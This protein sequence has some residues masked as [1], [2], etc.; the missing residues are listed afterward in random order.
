MKW[1]TVYREKVKI[2]FLNHKKSKNRLTRNYFFVGTAI[3]ILINILIFVIGGSNW[4]SFVSP[5][6]YLSTVADPERIVRSFL[7]VFSHAS[8][9]WLI[10]SILCLLV[11]GF[12]LER[13]V[14]SVRFV[15]LV[16]AIAFFS[17][18]AVTANF[19][20]AEWSGFSVA[21]FGLFGYIAA[22][23]MFSTWRDRQKQDN[24]TINIIFDVTAGLIIGGIIIVSFFGGEYIHNIGHYSALSAGAVFWIAIRIFFLKRKE[25]RG[26]DGELKPSCA[27]ENDKLTAET[28]NKKENV[29][30]KNCFFVC[31]ITLVAAIIL[32]YAT[33]G[34]DWP[35]FVHVRGDIGWN[36]AFY[37]NPTIRAFLNAFAHLNTT[38]VFF[39]VTGLFVC[40]LYL[41][42]KTGSIKLLIM[43]LA[44][45]F[46]TSIVSVAST[47][48]AVYWIGFSGVL[49][50]LYAYVTVDYIFS[51][52]FSKKHLKE[53]IFGTVVLLCIYIGMS[54]DGT[55]SF[56]WYPYSL[57]FHE[58][59]LAGFVAGLGLGVIVQIV[60][61]RES[62]LSLPVI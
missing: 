39:N 59:H 4:S 12:F 60:N 30:T 49:Y 50:L 10:F 18:A 9:G 44:L 14:G 32:L 7:N 42:R 8:A 48:N 31:T 16:L 52:R 37:F 57:I 29:F 5:N 26:G 45:V 36:E 13:K 25:K 61:K 38:H 33:G 20:S 24:K 55:L 47:L 41:E 28:E 19:L 43:I 27:V 46:F 3:I 21:A 56:V 40:G 15:L 58:A 22:G 11:C 35:H 17:A 53:V 34:N 54:F 62:S 1:Y 51:F 2:I 6:P 23:D